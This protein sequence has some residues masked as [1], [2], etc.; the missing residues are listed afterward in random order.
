MQT[1]IATVFFLLFPLTNAWVRPDVDNW[2]FR[3]ADALNLAHNEF[4]SL[5]VAFA[6]SAAWAYRRFAWKLWAFAVAVSA[7]LMW[8]HHL[9]DIVAGVALAVIVMRVTERESTW[10]EL[11]CLAQCAR[12]SRTG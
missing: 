9:L 8:E 4:P 5:H 2:A 12:F 10:V 1:I 11:C 3:L 7:W 6:V